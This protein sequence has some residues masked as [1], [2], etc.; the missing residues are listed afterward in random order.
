I[1]LLRIKA[2]FGPLRKSKSNIIIILAL[3]FIG[4]GLVPIIYTEGSFYGKLITDLLLQYPII[5]VFPLLFLSS[6]FVS[7][8]NVA[9]YEYEF[10]LSSNVRPS[11]FLLAKTL[12]DL[13]IALFLFFLPLIIPF[14]I[15]IVLMKALFAFLFSSLL[16]ILIISIILE[17]SFKTLILFYNKNLVRFSLITMILVFSFPLFYNLYPNYFPFW[18]NYISPVGCLQNILKGSAIIVPIISLSIWL[19][20]SLLLLIKASSLNFI[21]Y[22]QVVPQRT[23]F[24]IS[25]SSQVRK[26]KYVLSKVGIFSIPL[27]LSTA[28]KNMI[29]FFVKESIT[30]TLRYGDLYTLILTTFFLYLPYIFLQ[31][32]YSGFSSLYYLNLSPSYF[33]II[34]YPMIF[35]QLWFTEFSECIWLVKTYSRK[36]F[37]F[38]TGFFIWQLSLTLPILFIISILD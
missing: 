38:S 16:A 28:P 33:I 36:F 21:P 13:T 37:S 14:I 26:Q 12:Y 35:S 8:M 15:S 9:E 3:P 20:I 1:Y 10:I 34:F 22:V 24:D 11:D 7:K 2:T 29:L 27:D 25:L 5:L 30:R 18:L 32:Q 19:T 31:P 4:L 6:V 23:M 17:N